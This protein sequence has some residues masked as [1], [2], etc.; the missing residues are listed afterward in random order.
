M[1]PRIL[2]VDDE[3]QLRRA[4]TRSLQRHGY[5]TREAET[6]SATLASFD[7][8]RPDVVLLDLMLPDVSGVDV[9]RELRKAH[10]TPIIILSIVGEEQAKVAALDEGA[11]DYVTKPFGMDELLARVRVAL[12]RGTSERGQ[13]PII[14]VDGLTVDVEKRRVLL[15]GADVHLSPT[16]YSLLKCTSPFTPARS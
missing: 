2:I 13:Q 1:K 9:C 11:D 5:D 3:V 4:V 8:Y 14:K 6:G 16:E 12:R 10:Q 7:S 15:D